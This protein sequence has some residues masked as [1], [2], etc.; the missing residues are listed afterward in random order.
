MV[1][2]DWEGKRRQPETRSMYMIAGGNGASLLGDKE[3]IRTGHE[4]KRTSA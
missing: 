4:W 1:K 2:K 3:M